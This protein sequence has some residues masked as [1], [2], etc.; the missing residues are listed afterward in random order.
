MLRF[1]SMSPNQEIGLGFVILEFGAIFKCLQCFKV[2][3]GAKTIMQ[4]FFYLTLPHFLFLLG[5]VSP[6]FGFK[7]VLDLTHLGL[8]EF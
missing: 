8:S 1:M 6:N 7:N 4:W 2:L 5:E 3:K